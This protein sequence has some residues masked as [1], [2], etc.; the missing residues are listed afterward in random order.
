[1]AKLCAGAKVFLAAARQSSAEPVLLQHG[2]ERG[3][4]E[5]LFCAVTAELCLGHAK[6]KSTQELAA[7]LREAYS[8]QA[9]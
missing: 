6:R 5:R 4:V 9:G 7:E 3:I 8:K 1:M 2:F